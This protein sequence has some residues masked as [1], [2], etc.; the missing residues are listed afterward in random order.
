MRLRFSSPLPHTHSY[1]QP[2][3]PLQPYWQEF[4]RCYQPL[5]YNDKVI[6]SSGLWTSYLH[7]GTVLWW[8]AVRVLASTNT[9][10]WARWPQLDNYQSVAPEILP[11]PQSKTYWIWDFPLASLIHLTSSLTYPVFSHFRL[12]TLFFLTFTP[13]AKRSQKNNI[14]I[15]SDP[16]PKQIGGN[17]GLQQAQA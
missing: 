11:A 15:H 13:L 4:L 14:H 16:I 5:T 1:T 17:E 12:I 10:Q 3:L 6:S 2:S 7:M 8:P 9:L